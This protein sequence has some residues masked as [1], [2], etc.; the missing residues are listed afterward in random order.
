MRAIKIKI[1]IIFTN[2]YSYTIRMNF[3]PNTHFQ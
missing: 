1:Q 3:N 2:A